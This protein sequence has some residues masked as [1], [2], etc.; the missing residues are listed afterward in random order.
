MIYY[1]SFHPTLIQFPDPEI[2][3]SHGK[4]GAAFHAMYLQSDKSMGVGAVNLLVGQIFHLITIDPGL[5]TGSFGHN[6]QLV[7]TI[8][9]QIV[10]P[11]LYFFMGG[12]PSGAQRFPVN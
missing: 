5:N 3:P 7:P 9:M 12:K 10:V 4:W 1:E 11:V 8:V 2:P 6:P